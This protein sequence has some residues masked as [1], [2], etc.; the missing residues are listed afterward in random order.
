MFKML[1]RILSYA[2]RSAARDNRRTHRKRRDLHRAVLQLEQLE[3]RLVPSAFVWTNNNGAG[4]NLWETATNWTRTGGNAGDTPG[5]NAT[6]NTLTTA[7]TVTF[8]NNHVDDVT[9]STRVLTL[10]TMTMS[11]YTG[12]ITLNKDLTV[13]SG[14]SMDNGTIVQGSGA[15]GTTL[16]VT[17]GTFTWTGGNINWVSGTGLSKGFL[18]ISATAEVDFANATGGTVHFGDSITNS[19]TLKL[20]NSGVLNTVELNFTPTITNSPTGKINITV[21][22]TSGLTN[23]GAVVT[24]QNSG[25]I[26]KT[27]ADSG[28][29]D[30]SDP[31]NNKVAGATLQ[32]DAG[33]LDFISG[34]PSTGYSV[35]QSAGVIQ[36]SAAATLEADHGMTQ[37]GG[38]TRTSGA[39]TATINGALT[40][41]GGSLQ[42]GNGTP[43]IGD[44]DLIGNFT[45][46]GGTINLVYDKTT[47]T[48]SGITVTGNATVSTTGTTLTV[49]F[50]GVGAPAAFNVMVATGAISNVAQTNNV[51]GFTASISGDT[52]TYQEM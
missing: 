7:D 20:A 37:S 46:S 11:G 49:S 27:A 39:G 15:T 31:V 51:P 28:E 21:A 18:I 47:S 14:G 25:T 30:I 4:N 10:A 26:E 12:K 29:Y 22:N 2:G 40:M 48:N 50:V 33:T 43:T 9:M 32:V 36:I 19:G 38:T 52:H 34:D 3:T 6:T 44:I 45:W 35:T 23:S 24:I 8:D 13:N 16:S 42:A 17:G 41:S 5:W 1:E